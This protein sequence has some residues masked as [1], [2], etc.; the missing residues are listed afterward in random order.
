MGAAKAK[1]ESAIKALVVKS[2]HPS[3]PTRVFRQ[4]LLQLTDWTQLLDA[5]LSPG[6]QAEWKKYRQALRNLGDEI[7]PL[8]AQVKWPVPPHPIKNQVGRVVIE[9]DG[10]PVA[11]RSES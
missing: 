10:T 11:N 4:R 7:H 9:K 5:P 8:L 6:E 2:S 1:N 3:P